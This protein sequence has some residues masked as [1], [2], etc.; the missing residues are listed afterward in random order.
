MAMKNPHNQP[1]RPSSPLA[2][3]AQQR[4][5]FIQLGNCM[6]LLLLLRAVVLVMLLGFE[7]SHGG[8]LP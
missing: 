6:L 1:I 7:L 8:R 4:N 2:V 5:N 3:R